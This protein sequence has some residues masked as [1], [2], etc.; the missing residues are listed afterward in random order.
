MKLGV[1]MIV[2]NEEND[3]PAC[4][5]SVKWADVL[6][7]VDTGS[8]DRTREV[9]EHFCN[10]KGFA[11]RDLKTFRS[12]ALFISVSP[13]T[14][15][16]CIYITYTEAS[17]QVDG[18]WL[19][20]DFS[21]ARN[22]YVMLLDSI[23]DW[24]LWMDAD[25]VLLDPA[26]V[27]PLL[28]EPYDV[29]SFP[30][31]AKAGEKSFAHHRLWR[32]KQGTRYQG[33]CHEYPK[34]PLGSRVK[35]TSIEIL[36]RWGHHDSQEPSA[37][38]N[39][40]I[41][42]REYANPERRTP[43]MLF[44]LANSYRDAGKLREAVKVYRE[45]LVKPSFHEEEMFARLYLARCLRFL[46]EFGAAFTAGFEALA[47]DQ[48]FSEIWMELAYCFQACKQPTRALGFAR[49]ALQPIPASTLFPEPNKYTDQPHRIMSFAYEALGD[50]EQALH[51]TDQVLKLHPTDAD[52]GVRRNRL[53][54]AVHEVAV[55]RPGAAGDILMTLHVLGPLKE[56]YP[57]K[58]LIY[59]CHPNFHGL[60]ALSTDVDEVRSHEQYKP[61][62]FRDF[63]LI[64]YPKKE[65]YP[66]KPMRKHLVEY[67]ADEVG[68]ASE[69]PY[70]GWTPKA[71]S[72]PRPPKWYVTIHT[73]AGWSP[74]K[75]WPIERWQQIVHL[76]KGLYPSLTIVHIGAQ[77]DPKLFG[78]TDMRGL[79][80]LEESCYLI[81]RAHAHL[82]VD[83]FS[84]HAT[85]I[86][87]KTRAVILW[88]STSPTG[89]GYPHNIN[90]H[91]NPRGC[92]P[93]YKEFEHMSADPRGKCPHDPAQSWNKP[94]H[95]C[96]HELSVDQVWEAVQT[97]VRH[98]F[99]S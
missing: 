17:E 41:L 6:C 10:D 18:K 7:I 43:R 42:E 21:M 54:R 64:G 29:F 57:N 33:A 22:A 27:L 85:A 19:L 65:G 87:D 23:V 94:E 30:I 84:N 4:L 8:T 15:R 83:S 62:H 58:R 93:C 14:E 37:S 77:T 32:T 40:R 82:G 95:P 92:S 47:R 28:Q 9:I 90:L 63:N 86:G 38:R 48:R 71:L 78:V 81:Q 99:V 36:H 20:N 12:A 72:T 5:E 49:S 1:G 69:H 75:N 73:Q 96:L 76:L 79:T 74:Y 59:Y 25:D 66:D 70:P 24:V 53:Y 56:K 88:G 2:K 80:T 26:A 60:A 51:H 97:V 39:L 50:F 68:V 52:F 67:F 45:Y 91:L 61:G 3:L 98:P 16:T 31:V 55:H 44:Y 34:W 13:P 46:N 11:F 89:S 35:S